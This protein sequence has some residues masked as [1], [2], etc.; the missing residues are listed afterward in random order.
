[1]TKVLALREKFDHMSQYSGYDVLYRHLPDDMDVDDV[2]CNFKKMYPRGIGR[3]L[4]TSSGFFSRSSFY[5]AQSVEAELKLLSK[6]S[7]NNYAL[8]HYTYGEPY[9]AMGSLFKRFIK[10]AVVVTNHQP[11]NWWDRHSDLFKRYNEA[12]TV[13]T[14][15]E[16]DKEYFNAH[17]PGK[18][19]CTPHGVDISFYKPSPQNKP[20]D[21]KSFKVIFSGRYL[22]DMETLAEVIKKLSKSSVSFHFDI[23]YFDKVLVTES[24]LKDIMNLPNVT[25][26]A[27][28][29]E[30]GLL[31]LYQQAD[32]CLIPLLDC[33]ANNAILEAIACGVPVVSTDLPS[34]RTYL[35]DSIS[36]LG[37]KSNAD[38]LCEAL[39]LLH[40]DED[41]RNSMAINAR[42]KAVNQF[43]WDI[44][45]DKTAEL[46]R[47][48]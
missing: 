21:S 35:D 20:T 39:L 4:S 23:V 9:Y 19:I 41:K 11:A 10:S 14:L 40:H 29:S 5:N 43:S 22:R 32:C 2:F 28:V 42:N 31:S 15:S 46:F 13:I 33:T 6:S 7:K 25:W 37:R 34:I 44:I 45:A 12:H 16:Y 48:I 24:Y 1:M 27:N 8:I 3:L 17:V 47:S 18:A 36:I 30:H 26:H 38:D